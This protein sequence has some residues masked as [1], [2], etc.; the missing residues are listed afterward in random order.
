V[1]VGIVP[2][3]SRP[4]VGGRA[5]AGWPEVAVGDRGSTLVPGGRA[6]PDVVVG[7]AALLLLAARGGGSPDPGVAGTLEP[8]GMRGGAA[9]PVP[10][11]E[12]VVEPGPDA[13]VLVGI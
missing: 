1:R 2:G 11:L 6:A 12:G 9:G 4:A 10:G 7:G 8:E 3:R 13:I 5:E